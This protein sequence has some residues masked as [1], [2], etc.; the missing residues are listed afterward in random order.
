MRLSVDEGPLGGLAP[1]PS[2]S[3]V[4]TIPFSYSLR[5]VL[6]RDQVPGPYS[7]RKIVPKL[8]GSSELPEWAPPEVSDLGGLG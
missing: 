6:T 4:F 2:A 8:Q 5:P 7:S 3:P 1:V